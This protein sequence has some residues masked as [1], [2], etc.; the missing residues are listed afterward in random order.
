VGW[1]G[2]SVVIK[3]RADYANDPSYVFPQPGT[4]VPGIGDMAVITSPQRTAGEITVKPGADALDIYVDF[5]TKPVD[6]AFLAT[7]ARTAV[8]RT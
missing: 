7:L 6:N 3:T 2:L 8:E 4:N 1:Q 5:Y